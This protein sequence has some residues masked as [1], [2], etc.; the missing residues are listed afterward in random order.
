MSNYGLEEGLLAYNADNTEY[1]NIR[2]V[3]SDFT[4]VYVILDTILAHES[5]VP[6]ILETLIRQ[7]FQDENKNE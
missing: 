3:W 6:I 2:K 7:V 4:G 1:I 5:P